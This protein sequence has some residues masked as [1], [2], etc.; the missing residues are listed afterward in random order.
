MTTEDL[1]F[2]FAKQVC[3]LLPPIVAQ[4]IRNWIFPLPLAYADNRGFESFSQ[5]GSLYKGK[6]GEHH[7][8]HFCM[9]GYN[10][11]RI[12]SIARV[13]CNPGDSI[14]EVGA[15]VGT[16][17]IGFSDIV[18]DAG[19]VYAYEPF[20]D[21][22]QVLQ[23]LF[24][25]GNKKNVLIYDYALDKEN[26]TRLFATPPEDN[27][28]LGH[29]INAHSDTTDPV[30]E[31]RCLTLDSQKENLV[32]P[33]SL[34]TLD[35]EGDELPVLSGAEHFIESVRPNII[36]EVKKSHMKRLGYKP[37]DLYNQ[38]KSWDYEIYEITKLGLTQPD[39]NSPKQSNWLCL[40]IE[41]KYLL[42]KVKRSLLLSGILPC[43]RGLNPLCS[44]QSHHFKSSQAHINNLQTNGQHHRSH[45]SV[46]S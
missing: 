26:R 3:R 41:K 15:N 32:L 24:G 28:G 38:L 44:E 21:N 10:D 18:K 45:Q 6:I 37:A 16:E 13:L 31:V 43:I 33:V 5:T 1:R 20:P 9:H 40:P 2:K 14:V 25:N 23:D 12:I 29:M 36:L 27:S 4:R 19:H 22:F 39:V 8:Y 42:G 35:V 46:D 7:G 30:I 34:M 11:W 17:T